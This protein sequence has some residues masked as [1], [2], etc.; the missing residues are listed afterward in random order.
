MQ[1]RDCSSIRRCAILRILLLAT[2]VLA[3]PGLST[4]QNVGNGTNYQ[5]PNAPNYQQ[6]T[7]PPTPNYTLPILPDAPAPAA[8]AADGREVFVKRIEVR[9][10][11]AFKPAVIAATVARYENRRVSSGDLQNLRVILTRLYVDKGYLN[12]SVILPD[13]TSS[14]GLV[15]FQAIEGSLSRINVSRKGKLSRSYITWRIRDHVRVPL[16]IAD[17]QYALRYIQED[18]NVLRLDARL[19]SG[20]GPG[21]SVLHLSVE[22]QPR[23]SAGIG[24][25]NHHSATTGANEGTISL[26][27]RDLTGYGDEIRGT[28]VRTKGDTEGS[29]I[30]SIPIAPDNASF[31][32]Y[33]SRSSA[34]IIEQLYQALDIKETTRTYGISFTVPLIDSLNNRPSLFLGME[35]DRSFTQLLNVPFSFSPGA[36]NGLSAV[37]VVQGGTDWAVHGMSYVTDLRITYKHGVDALGA[38]ISSGGLNILGLNPDPTGA[39]GRFGLEQFQFIYIQRLNA[40]PVLK[41]MNDRAQLIVRGSGQLSQQ[42]LLLLEKFTI[43]GVDTVRGFPENLLV[44][45]EGAAATIELQFPIPGYRAVPNFRDLA[46]ATFVDCGRS[47]D[48]VN[49]DPDNPLLSTTDPLYLASAGLGL[50]WNPLRGLDAQVYWGRSIANNF[51]GAD[52]PLSGVPTGLQKRGIQFALNYVYRW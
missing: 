40:V 39:D 25:D 37:A 32:A 29:G 3:I 9:G 18:P 43:G 45:D 10:V 4:A 52:D 8:P 51:R 34:G 19:G 6:P 50:L 47:W 41:W 38:T 12:S 13:Q 17:L 48:K 24:F 1:R 28:V 26:G 7:V 35:S 44:R 22:D 11:K 33:Y 30:F 20:D 2:A 21:Q 36:Q 27:G 49:T 5:N 23:L 42:P 16:N 31:Q 46:L 15:Y 14:D